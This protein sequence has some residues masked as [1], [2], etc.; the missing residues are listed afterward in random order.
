MCVYVCV[1]VCITTLISP[2]G[3]SLEILQSSSQTVCNSKTYIHDR[4]HIHV[5]HNI[6]VVLAAPSPGAALAVLDGNITYKNTHARIH[7]TYT[8]KL[9][10]Q[11]LLQELRSQLHWTAQVR[12]KIYMQTYIIHT[13]RLCWQHRQ[14]ER[15]SRLYWTAYAAL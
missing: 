6:Q 14:Q 7:N 11:H 3:M 15:L 1:C 2:W 5:Y 13:C 10:W 12:I 4:V 8:Y 9:S